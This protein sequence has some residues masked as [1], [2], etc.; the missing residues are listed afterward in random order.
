MNDK[1]AHF[2]PR[3]RGIALICFAALIAI[4]P[5]F[6]RGNSCSHDFDFH[7]VSWFDALQSWRDGIIYPHWSTNANFNAGEPRFI[8]YP[9][10]S[11]MLAA[12]FG[13]IMPWKCVPLAITWLF[14]AG[15][16]IATRA[17]ARQALEEGPATLAGCASLFSGYALYTAY[18][19]SDFGE[20]AGGF[21][22]PLVLLLMFRERNLDAPLLHRAFDG[23]T[24][25]L[26]I[27]IAGAWLSNAP[28][29]VMACYLLAAITL[30][31][32]WQRKSWAPVVR[33]TAAVVLGLG[34]CSFFII[35]AAYEQ[36]WVDMRNILDD[37]GYKVENN[38]LFA[39]H[40]NPALE[41]HDVELLKASAIATTMLAV[42]F[43]AFLICWRRGRLREQR[44]W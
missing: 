36:R 31:L 23:S 28:L 34:V 20:L 33:A 11:W 7:L 1:V 12:A 43:V 6:L 13:A 30:I 3:D 41:L 19:R 24:A 9:P 4:A 8:F 14:L 26:A 22:I 32:A 21:W 39:R 40:A 17:L 42:A 37:P 16:G 38:W 29:G 2:S 18:E 15:A 35:P 5:Q 44:H 10:I 25:S 27:V